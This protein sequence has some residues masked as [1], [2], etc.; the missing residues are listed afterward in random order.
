VA[1]F[2]GRETFSLDNKGRVSIPAKMRKSIPTEAEN[3]FVVTRGLEKCIYAYPINEWNEQ[4]QKKFEKLNQFDPTNRQMLRRMLEWCEDAA[5]D[6]QQR[7]TLPK[8]LLE[9]AEIDGKIT[10]VG[11]FDHIEFWNPEA[12][13]KYINNCDES[14][15]TIVEKVL[16][17]PNSNT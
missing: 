10:V 6:V 11:V 5:L 9:L 4:F 13:E 17:T 3:T 12:Y 15:E 2:K 14:Y 1:L 16:T 7:M 8:E